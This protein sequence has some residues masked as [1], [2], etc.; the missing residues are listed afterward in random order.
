MAQG[1][2]RG[3]G[4]EVSTK[5]GLLSP[6]I[7]VLLKC[8]SRFSLNFVLCLKLENLWGFLSGFEPG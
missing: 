3:S 7:F 2:L 6:L 1:P 8:Y 5:S 4:W